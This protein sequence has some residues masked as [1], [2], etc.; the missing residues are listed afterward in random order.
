MTGVQTCALPISSN[1]KTALDCWLAQD[2]YIDVKKLMVNWSPLSLIGE[3]E[4]NFNENYIPKI[5]L[6]TSSKGLF[7][8]IENLEQKKWLDS[9]GVFVAKILLEN[10]AFKIKDSDKHLSVVTP[11]SY[12][13]N[14]LTVEKISIKKFS[15]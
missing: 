1:Y 8:L 4:L 10:K 7:E 11:I 15:K 6:S 9:K 5:K 3:G 12:N 13:D 2:G 14:I